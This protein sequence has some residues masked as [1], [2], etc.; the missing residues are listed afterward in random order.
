MARHALQIPCKPT[1]C[2]YECQREEAGA[3]RV[4]AGR[5]VRR[6][7][8]GEAEGGAAGARDVQAAP[9]R[10]RGRHAVRRAPARV[11]RQ[12]APAPGPLAP[13]RA[14]RGRAARDASGCAVSKRRLNEP[15][16]GRGGPAKRSQLVRV[17][18]T[19][20]LLKH[21]AA[22][23]PQRRRPPRPRQAAGAAARA[24]RPFE[25]GALAVRS[26]RAVQRA[27]HKVAHTT[28][29]P[30]CTP[31]YTLMPKTKPGGGR[32]SAG[33]GWRPRTPA[34]AG[35]PSAARPRDPAARPLPT[36]AAARRSPAPG[37][38]R[39]RRRRRPGAR[40][41]CP[42]PNG[43][44][45][46]SVARPRAIPPSDRG[47]PG[48]PPQAPAARGERPSDPDGQDTYV[49]PHSWASNTAGA[50]PPA[51]PP[52]GCG[53]AFQQAAQVA[54][55][56][57]SCTRRCAAGGISSK[58]TMHCA[59]G[60]RTAPPAGAAA[61]AAAGGAARAVAPAAAAAAAAA[62]CALMAA[63][64]SQPCAASSSAPRASPQSSTN[65]TWPTLR[66]RWRVTCARRASRSR[67]SVGAAR[68]RRGR[69]RLRQT[70]RLL[71]RGTRMQ[72]GL[73]GADRCASTPAPRRSPAKPSPFSP[74]RCRP[75]R[76][77]PRAPR[78]RRRPRCCRR[79]QS[80]RRRRRRRSHPPS[81]AAA[82]RGWRRWARWR[83]RRPRRRRR[84]RRA[85]RRAPAPPPGP[86]GCPGRT[87]ARTPGRCCRACR[88]QAPAAA[89]PARA[90]RRPAAPRGVQTSGL[91]TS[92][93][94]TGAST[95]AVRGP[96]RRAR[97]S[98]AARVRGRLSGRAP[99]GTW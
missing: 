25:P 89:A 53:R 51:R 29:T 64:S 4:A 95:R 5:L 67:G 14:A 30:P 18:R 19:A 39:G 31:P 63:G 96:A 12:R 92:E 20:R 75:A 33:A 97:G 87:A 34:P 77:S 84:R 3:R 38:P 78:R 28:Y 88:R 81:P 76:W 61:A 45:P 71:C 32:T 23:S 2:K 93:R 98:Q 27:H 50:G 37:R 52:A 36:P 80:R 83:A 22:G 79:R 94:N 85:P 15:S 8:A 6:A 82:G 1:P 16:A 70:G 44:R 73:P 40:A 58:H 13:A 42:T 24:P 68:R 7:Q 62:W 54:C 46:P 49:P 74:H 26:G 65:A 35:A 17:A 21:G 69:A 72:A 86:A 47:S 91:F 55:P 43:A 90:A 57:G 10:G 48:R 66:C 59:A 41:G 60:D 9:G 56:H 11:Q 99:P